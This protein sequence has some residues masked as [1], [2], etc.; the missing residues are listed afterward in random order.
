MHFPHLAYIGYSLLNIS[1]VNPAKPALSPRGPGFYDII[2]G[3]FLQLHPPSALSI[4]PPADV[5]SGGP[6]IHPAYGP[7]TNL[8]IASGSLY[9][10]DLGDVNA[11]DVEDKAFFAATTRGGELVTFDLLGFR[12]INEEMQKIFERKGTRDMRYGETEFWMTLRGNTGDR[13]LWWVNHNL[14]I[15]NGRLLVDLSTGRQRAWEVRL[16]SPVN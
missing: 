8:T 1:I 6:I 9:V 5:P 7:T 14:I 2:T 10:T 16:F 15:G 3:G 4:P 12:K 11:A 13:E